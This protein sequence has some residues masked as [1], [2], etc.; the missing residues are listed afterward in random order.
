MYQIS[1]PPPPLA[2][3]YAAEPELGHALLDLRARLERSA[4][5][6]IRG[7]EASGA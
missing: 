2:E 6:A 1:T 4:L 5:V 3:L 7:L